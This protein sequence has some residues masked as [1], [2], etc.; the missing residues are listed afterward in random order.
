[1]KRLGWLV[2]SGFA[3]ALAASALSGGEALAQSK[4]LRINP[5]VSLEP[6]CH[7]MLGH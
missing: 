2:L 6:A 5:V 1:M 3:F 4:T 7:L